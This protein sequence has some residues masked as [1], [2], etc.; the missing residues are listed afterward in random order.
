MRRI[1]ENSEKAE[2]SEKDERTLSITSPK[3]AQH[4]PPCKR[5]ASIVALA[6]HRA[7]CR[8]HLM[9]DNLA[10]TLSKPHSTNHTGRRGLEGCEP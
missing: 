4:K 3:N 5:K 2:T 6:L 8:S 1:A 7:I 9:R 10:Q